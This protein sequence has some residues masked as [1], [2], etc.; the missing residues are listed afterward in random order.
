MAERCER[1]VDP[2]LPADGAATVTGA[3]SMR[4]RN[5]LVYL[6]SSPRGGSTLLSELLGRHRCGA[7]LGEV[8]FI[9]KHLALGENCTCGASVRNCPV[10]SR[11]FANLAR[12]SGVDLRDDPYGLF[13]GDAIKRKQTGGMVDRQHQGRA[14]E[15]RAK[16]RGFVDTVQLS[17]TP[18][19][20]LMRATTLPSIRSAVRNT[21][22]LYDAA[23]GAFEAT[24]LVDAS[25]APR[26][27]V[28]LY[29][30]RPDQVRII[31][32]VRDGRSVCASRSVHMPIGRAAERWSH[33]QKLAMSLVDRWVEPDHWRALRYEDLVADPQARL[34]ELLEWLGY[35]YDDAMLDFSEVHESHSAGGNPARFRVGGGITAPEEKWRN[36][37]STEDMKTFEVHAGAMN[38]RFGYG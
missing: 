7:N 23:A 25:K 6:F 14:R 18:G 30:E 12:S 32:L 33:Y 21:F 16:L 22:K 11:A 2:A 26:K 24:L 31:H 35:E 9:P 27:G 15:L 17:A 13:I 10:W 29:L 34:S 8:G 37:F 1:I 19:A 28:H 20:A 36:A 3:E 5:V 4:D 38:R